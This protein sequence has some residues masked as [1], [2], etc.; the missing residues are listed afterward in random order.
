MRKTRVI[1]T[2][3]HISTQKTKQIKNI[4]TNLK[5]FRQI[6]TFCIYDFWY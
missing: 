4:L 5:L 3:I 1:H 6:L 2:L